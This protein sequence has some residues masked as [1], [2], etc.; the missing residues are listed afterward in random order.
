MDLKFKHNYGSYQTT[1]HLDQEAYDALD[2]E[3]ET[4]MVD[5]LKLKSADLA[6]VDLDATRAEAERICY[7]AYGLDRQGDLET[8]M[9][10]VE[11]CKREHARR[12]Q[13][14]FVRRMGQGNLVR[15]CHDMADAIAAAVEFAD[16]CPAPDALDF[17]PMP[18]ALDP[19]ALADAQNIGQLES[20]T[21]GSLRAAQERHD[22]AC[23]AIDVLMAGIS[24]QRRKAIAAI[25]E[26]E[27]RDAAARVKAYQ[28][29]LD[30]IRYERER[31]A[32]ADMVQELGAERDASVATNL[33]ALVNRVAKLERAIGAPSEG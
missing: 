22:S 33:F 21:A 24:A 6:D 8:G 32:D 25:I 18:T 15:R 4:L 23:A 20:L 17:G 16:E 3:E 28:A 14:E 31:R 29:N 30:A 11:A 9:E 10:L 27:K 1:E 7:L 19:D 13:A 2:M 26:A 5:A 12:T